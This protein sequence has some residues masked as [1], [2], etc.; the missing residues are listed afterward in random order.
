MASGRPYALR[1]DMRRVLR[2]LPPPA[3]TEQRPGDS[4]TVTR[5]GNP[6]RWGDVVLAR[7]EVRGSYHLAVVVDDAFQEITHVVRGRD[8]EAA[9]DLHRLLQTLL[10]FPVPFYFHH[11]LILDDKGRKLSKSLGSESIRFHR[12]MGESPEELIAGLGPF[13]C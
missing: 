2:A 10:G 1:L 3:W 5:A 8:L 6:T 7:K 12:T 11:R 4:A 9:T 13:E